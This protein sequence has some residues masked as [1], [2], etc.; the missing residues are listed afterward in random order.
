MI[1][2]AAVAG[3]SY[4]SW[5]IDN[6][7]VMP[8]SH[9]DWREVIEYS[10]GIWLSYATGALLIHQLHPHHAD[11]QTAKLA[12]ALTKITAPAIETRTHFQERAHKLAS[13]LG[14]ALPILTG[15]LSIVVSVH[16][17]MQ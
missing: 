17:L 14:F 8:Q 11:K 4:V 13:L 10:V 3:M 9:R 16:T 12:E 1:G 6:A 5:L 7:P 15:I 2:I